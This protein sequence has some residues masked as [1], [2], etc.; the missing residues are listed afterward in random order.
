MSG[1][2]AGFVLVGG[3]SSR[4]RRDKA[5]L[6]YRGSTLAQYVAGEVERAAGSATLVGDPQ[7]YGGLGYPVVRDLAPGA[8]PL[9]AI[10][11]ALRSSAAEWNLV[12]ACDMPR[13]TAP[14]LAQLLESAIARDAD[15]LVPA[16]PSG[17]PEPLCAVYRAGCLPVLAA[18]AARGIRKVMDG[19]AGTEL[20]ILPVA[21]PDVF[22]N[23]NTPEDWDAHSDKTPEAGI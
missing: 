21:D 1:V 7:R 19:L 17:F 20:Q 3:A 18:A 22:A 23:S 15:C 6:P 12:V 13:V 4:M 9:G 16:G 2:C 10:C 11:S 14:F 8:G 5:L